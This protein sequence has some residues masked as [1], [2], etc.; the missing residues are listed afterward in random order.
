VSADAVRDVRDK[1][2]LWAGNIGARNAPESAF[3][4]ESRLGAAVE[5]L[6]QVADLINDLIDA[7]ATPR[8]RFSKALQT[9][10]QRKT[11]FLDQF[12]ISHVAERY[13]KLKREDSRWLC[14]RLGR[15]ITKRRQVL[16]YL[17]DHRS[18]AGKS[19][20]TKVGSVSTGPST[21]A[22]TL[23][24][25]RLALLEA[26]GL[27]KEDTKSYVSASS[28]FLM[29]G[30]G[31][32]TLSLPSLAEVSKGE[33]I[34]EC[35]LCFG[36][37]TMSKDWEWRQHVF[38]D[39]KAYVCT[40]GNAECDV[41]LFGDSQSWFDH[42]MQCHR[43]K[44]VCILCYKG[45]FGSPQGIEAHI[46]TAHMNVLAHGSPLQIIMDASQQSV[47][48]LPARECPFCDDWA[49]SL[50]VNTTFPEGVAAT[51]VVVTVEPKQFRRH[52]AFHQEQLALFAIPRT[53]KDRNDGKG[54][55]VSS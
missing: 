8:D 26:G 12:D 30:S 9:T 50:E 23:D 22:S 15:A 41:N 44:W 4:L 27:D 31:D 32:A 5:L 1:F 53:L 6:E 24:V 7:L 45:P 43:R 51:E 35:P 52:V 34:F 47:D 48:F 13:P 28:S 11:P 39:L 54:T 37:Q 14:E 3:S 40:L 46:Q 10:G 38:A 49:E 25:A 19:M 33:A 36:I 21:K 18:R 55:Q 42:E 29:T 17:H 2:W 16:R 20:Y